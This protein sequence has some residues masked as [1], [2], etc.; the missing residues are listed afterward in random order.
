[1]DWPVVSS[2]SQTLHFI[3]FHF[4]SCQRQCP[5]CYPSRANHSHSVGACTNSLDFQSVGDPLPV[6]S[7]VSSLNEDGQPRQFAL[8]F[9]LMELWL[10]RRGR[11]EW[12]WWWWW[13]NRLYSHAVTVDSA[14]RG[15]VGDR[16]RERGCLCDAHLKR[17]VD[18]NMLLLERGGRC[19]SGGIK[20]RFYFSRDKFTFECLD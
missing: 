13:G 3:S 4:I 5:S 20:I 15:S 12:R 18:F 10:C 8:A 11:R 9:N 16:E 17:Q 1:M 19:S 2:D 6:L 7:L 14:G